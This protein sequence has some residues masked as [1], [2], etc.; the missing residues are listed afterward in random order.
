MSLSPA[1]VAA[2]AFA[3]ALLTECGS[4]RPSTPISPTTTRGPAVP[5]SATSYTVSGLV[6]ENGR[7]IAGA[8]VNAFVQSP[9]FGYSYMWAHGAVLTD[10]NGAFRLSDLAATATVWMQVY[11]DGYVQQCAV[12]PIAIE[13]DAS[14]N[15]QLV[16][17]ANVTATSQTEPRTV[18]GVIVEMTATGKQ[19]VAGAAVDFEPLE[20]FPAAITYTDAAGRFALCGLPQNQ[21][22]NLIASISG[23]DASVMVPAGQTS[24]EITLP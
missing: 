10:A 22:V 3:G 19:P 13:G 23:R 2:V 6:T 21:S 16:S 7:P 5:N 4:S 11:K 18:S 9:A 15:L 20:D 17:R 12:P 1:R 8:N 24:V 14:V